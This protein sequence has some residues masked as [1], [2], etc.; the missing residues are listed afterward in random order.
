[1]TQQ[2]SFTAAD[3]QPAQ[4]ANWK[5]APPK[6]ILN[7]KPFSLGVEVGIS[8]KHVAD[9]L[10]KQVFVVC[11]VAIKFRRGLWRQINLPVSI[12]I[13]WH[14]AQWPERRV[15]AVVEGP[16]CDSLTVK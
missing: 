10:A 11:S 12:I 9:R 14:F 7:E 3:I 13:N 5:F 6:E 16:D 8:R 2:V 15:D 4:L 1:M